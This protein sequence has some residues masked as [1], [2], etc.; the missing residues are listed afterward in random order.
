MQCWLEWTFRVTFNCFWCKHILPQSI[1]LG[2]TCRVLWIYLSMLMNDSPSIPAAQ[3]GSVQT[4]T[5]IPSF[6]ISRLNSGDSSWLWWMGRV[7]RRHMA[8]AEWGK[9]CPDSLQV[10]DG[11]KTLH[12]GMRDLIMAE[13][14]VVS[15]GACRELLAPFMK[16][17]G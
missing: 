9:P 3:K 17:Y 13:E 4:S 11:G 15:A 7:M 10:A 1:I 5:W 6:L 14:E 8:A 16:C 2:L 12:A